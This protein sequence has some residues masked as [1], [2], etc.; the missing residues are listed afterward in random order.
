MEYELDERMEERRGEGRN[1][2]SHIPTIKDYLIWMIVPSILSVVTCG[3]GGLI[4]MI[5]WAFSKENQARGNYF[6]AVLIMGLIGFAVGAVL[7]F[8]VLA[9]GFQIGASSASRVIY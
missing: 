7:W 1:L 3:I 4:L 9:L 5:V 2:E 6:K 8:V